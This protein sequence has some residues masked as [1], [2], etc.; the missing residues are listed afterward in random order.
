MF[1]SLSPSSISTSRHSSSTVTAISM[2]KLSVFIPLPACDPRLQTCHKIHHHLRQL[3]HSV[4]QQIR[5][6]WEGGTTLSCSVTMTAKSLAILIHADIFAT[7]FCM[8][9]II[10]QHQWLADYGDY[11]LAVMV[12]V[13]FAVCLQLLTT[14]GLKCR[15]YSNEILLQLLQL[16]SLLLMTQAEVVLVVVRRCDWTVDM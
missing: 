6:Y 12:R 10:N 3:L 13:H 4:F 8:S 16:Y 15:R 14:I 2:L 11:K 7:S 9:N 5:E 1:L